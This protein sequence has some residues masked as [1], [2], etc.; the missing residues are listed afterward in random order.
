MSP[1][2]S[3]LERPANE[4]RIRTAIRLVDE[5]KARLAETER[6]KENT[7]QTIEESKTSIRE[8]EDF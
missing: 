1:V 8:C 4:E 5:T 3:H 6:I 7:A 2:G